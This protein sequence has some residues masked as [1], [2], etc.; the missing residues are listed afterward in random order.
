MT[1]TTLTRTIQK[2]QQ[3]RHAATQARG[4]SHVR[5]PVLQVLAVEEELEALIEARARDFQSVIPGFRLRKS[6]YGGA[7][8]VGLHSLTGL[9]RRE[10]F[11]RIEFE[12]QIEAGGA[13]ARVR[14]RGTVRY[15]DMP[16]D[17]LD[18]V[19]D[20]EGRQRLVEFIES[21]FYAFTDRY[22]FRG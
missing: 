9:K 21:A 18:I 7:W 19:L 6:L 20:E 17:E 4:R 22:E 11:S 2:S 12:V 3:S 16:G 1:T 15:R 13:A 8:V 10:G 5:S 14:T